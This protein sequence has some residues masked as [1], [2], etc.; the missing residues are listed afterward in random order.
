MA[1]IF[2]VYFVVESM[3]LTFEHAHAIGWKEREFEH[4]S[5]IGNSTANLEGIGTLS[6]AASQENWLP[7]LSAQRDT[8]DKHQW[9]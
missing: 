5:P 7:H 2:M 6:G 1:L 9:P 3:C 8:R 4:A